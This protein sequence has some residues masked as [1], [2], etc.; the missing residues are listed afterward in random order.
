LKETPSQINP[1]ENLDSSLGE[2]IPDEPREE[3]TL[4]KRKINTFEVRNGG[5]ISESPIT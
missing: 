3:N 2:E 5:D 1:K 4:S